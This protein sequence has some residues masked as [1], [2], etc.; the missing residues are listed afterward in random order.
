MG[1]YPI[2]VYYPVTFQPQASPVSMRAPDP[3]A[4]SSPVVL[5]D[6]TLPPAPSTTIRYRRGPILRFAATEE[7]A[8]AANAAGE[9]AVRLY[10]GGP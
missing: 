1:D 3:Y 10:G 8:R 5:C 9:A 2:F 6:P 7:E 4:F